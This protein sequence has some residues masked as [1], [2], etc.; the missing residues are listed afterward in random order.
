[1]RRRDAGPAVPA[2]AV[3][4]PRSM[5]KRS[6][7]FSFA[8]L[9]LVAGV[10]AQDPTDAQNVKLE[11]EIIPS[12]QTISGDVTWTFR[13]TGNGLTSVTLELDS[14]FTV[15]NV[16]CAGLPAPFT[17]PANQ[18]VITLDHAYA[19]DEVFTVSLHY[20]GAPASGAG[21]GSFTFD[22]HGTPAQT[23]VSTLSEPFYAYTW[24]P[25]KDTLT[26]KFTSETWITVPNGMTATSGGLLLGTDPLTGSRTRFRWKSNY[27]IATYGVAV[28]ASNYQLRTDTYT[29]LGANTPVT[30]YAYPED[31]ASQQTNMDR[32]VTMMTTFSNLF[33]QYP[34]ANEK[35]GIV[36]FNWGGGMEHQTLSS[37]SSFSENLSAHEL[38]HSWWGNSITC[39]TWHDIGVN[40]GFATYSEALWDE[41]KPG[42]STS[43]YFS[44]M[45]LNKP[46]NPTT[47]GSVYVVNPTSVSTIFSTTNV[48]RKGAWVLH[49]LRHVVGDLMFFQILRDYQANLQ[50]SSATWADF[51]ASASATYG[52]DLTWFIDQC[53]MRTGAPRFQLGWANRT[54]GGQTYVVGHITQTHAGLPYRFPV[55]VRVTTAS[56]Q[57]FNKVWV[58]ETRDDFV[59][60]ANGA[61]TGVSVDPSPWIL[62]G[63]NQTTTFAASL[64]ASPASIPR[65]GG[66]VTFTLNGGAST[67]SRPYI[68]GASVAGI[69][70]GYVMPD[71]KVIPLVPDGV[72]DFVLANMN[73]PMFPNFSGAL[74]SQGQATAQLVLPDIGPI[75]APITVYFTWITNTSPMF[76]STPVAI[77]V[78]P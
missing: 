14:A 27:P 3:E 33:G 78:T 12:N 26:D 21:F 47:T 9:F 57:V 46:T 58:D 20:A 64:T 61:A 5:M 63:T 44:R 49:Q 53:V 4:A 74:S 19:Q 67:G 6:V 45:N 48:Y 52:Q 69:T 23:I 25:C 30:F 39:A 51:A 60:P 68:L 34:F 36:Q 18:V 54:L 40:E 22:T 43:A 65:T 29:G 31:F 71:G 35:Y 70:P 13:S 50:Y 15:S 7:I 28:T 2:F 24:W 73:G 75:P 59:F 11:I 8:V 38:A 76:V 56:G 16:Q 10:R 77:T 41:F 1:M 17:R 62:R 32:I 37:Q 66:T 55:D 42:G 72:T